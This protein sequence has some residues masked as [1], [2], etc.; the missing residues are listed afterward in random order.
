MSALLTERIFLTGRS[1][2]FVSVIQLLF[3]CKDSSDTK[4][5]DSRSGRPHRSKHGPVVHGLGRWDG[6]I[7]VAHRSRYN[8]PTF[9]NE[10]GLGSKKCRL[11]KN[12]VGHLSDFNGPH[13]VSD[14]MRDRR[15]N[16]IF[17]D[18]TSRSKVVMPV[19]DQ[20]SNEPN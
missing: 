14:A 13:F 4:V 5:A 3:F 17:C 7:R 9:Q 18:V 2:R 10:C 6:C 8:K 11:P 15:I 1:C 19:W 20:I 16:R 12:Q